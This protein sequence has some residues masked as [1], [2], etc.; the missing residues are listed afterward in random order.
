MACKRYCL[1]HEI[2]R[3]RLEGKLEWLEKVK[4]SNGKQQ[5]ASGRWTSVGKRTLPIRFGADGWVSDKTFVKRRTV[6]LQDDEA[7]NMK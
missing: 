6:C 5:L 4:M 1:N 7:C 3:E 2:M